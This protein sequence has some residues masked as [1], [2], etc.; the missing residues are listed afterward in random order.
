[1]LFT[2]PASLPEHCSNNNGANMATFKQLFFAL[3]VAASSQFT[4]A[5]SIDETVIVADRIETTRDS[6]AVSVNVIDRELISAL[7]S[8]TLPRYFDLRLEFPQHKLAVLAPSAGFG[9]EVRMPLE[10]AS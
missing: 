7:G 8:A 4:I 10:R 3:S 2:L 5:E 6:L 1:M 9:F